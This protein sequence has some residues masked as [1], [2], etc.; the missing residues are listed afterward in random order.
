MPLSQDIQAPADAASRADRVINHERKLKQPLMKGDS[1][2]YKTKSNVG[3]GGR[4]ANSGSAK[5]ALFVEA[6]SVI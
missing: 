1:H 3:P 6:L 5:V 2:D 4:T